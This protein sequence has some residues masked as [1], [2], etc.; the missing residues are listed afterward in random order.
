[1]YGLYRPGEGYWTRVMTA[2]AAGVI[3]LIGAG[4][5]WNLLRNL[6][7]G[8]IDNA[9][10]TY[11]A[12]ASAAVLV[13]ACGALIYWLVGVKPGSV[14][15]LVATEVEMKAVNWSTRREIFGSTWIV[16]M[17][18]LIITLFV[19]VFDLVFSYGFVRM[20]VLDAGI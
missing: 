11:V 12:G 8:F 20:G 18:S 3:A 14:D 16:L 15:F 1:M 2:I 7:V 13:L 5:L 17:L 6:R 10:M 4:W 19:S 9:T